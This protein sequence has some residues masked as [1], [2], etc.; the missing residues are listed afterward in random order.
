MA[1][2][3]RVLHSIITTR[4]TAADPAE[5][6]DYYYNIIIPVPYRL[7]IEYYLLPLQTIPILSPTKGAEKNYGSWDA[8]DARDLGRNPAPVDR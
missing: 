4:T 5:D 3:Y 6:D 8:W 1:I 2:R 7:L